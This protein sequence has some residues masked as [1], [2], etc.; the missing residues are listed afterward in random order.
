MIFHA[1]I[2]ELVYFVKNQELY[3][4]FYFFDKIY[5]KTHQWK[6]FFSPLD[7]IIPSNNRELPNPTVNLVQ[8]N[9]L[10]VLKNSLL[11]HDSKIFL[12]VLKIVNILKVHD[13][14]SYCNLKT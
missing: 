9:N 12:I 10:K 7:L 1:V 6:F 11:T 14:V 13:V 8:P 5:R 3:C 4:L 2:K